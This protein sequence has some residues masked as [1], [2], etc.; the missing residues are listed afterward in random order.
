[1][2]GR[3]VRDMSPMGLLAVASDN[4]NVSRSILDPRH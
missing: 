1:M 2:G 3:V 4:P